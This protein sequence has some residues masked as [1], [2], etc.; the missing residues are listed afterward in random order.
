MNDRRR[1]S[2]HTVAID[3]RLLVT[4]AFVLL[5]LWMLLSDVGHLLSIPKAGLDISATRPGGW[6]KTGGRLQEAGNRLQK[7]EVRSQ[8]AG[9]HGT[10][11]AGATVPIRPTTSK[12]HSDS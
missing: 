3:L 8:K 5:A 9:V 4:I 10:R 6:Q 1:F 7:T 11:Q 2:T 12:R